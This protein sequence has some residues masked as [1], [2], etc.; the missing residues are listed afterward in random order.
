MYADKATV[1][2]IFLANGFKTEGFDDDLPAHVYAATEALLKHFGVPTENFDQASAM[3][4]PPEIVGVA[5]LSR[6]VVYRLLAPNRHHD[7]IYT[8]SR[9]VEADN[10]A[11]EG[12]ID[13]GD[14]FLTR[15]QA[16]VRAQQTGQLRRR[17]GP[18]Y[19]QGPRLFSE[20]LW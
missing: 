6:G 1:K 19:Y 13:A 10:C 4:R 12:F 14:M 3:T 17:D 16:Y 9:D 8:L 18:Q 7:L 2:T 5:I 15:P 11:V 20:D